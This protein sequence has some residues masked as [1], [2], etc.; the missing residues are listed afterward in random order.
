MFLKPLRDI[1]PVMFLEVSTAHL[2]RIGGGGYGISHKKNGVPTIFLNVQ[3][4]VLRLF[5]VNVY[6][7]VI[8]IRFLRSMFNLM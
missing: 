3:N 2:P 4:C 8:R 6:Q 1:A 7:E 5:N